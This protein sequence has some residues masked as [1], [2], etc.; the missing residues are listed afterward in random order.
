MSDV[1]VLVK[2]VPENKKKDEAI[3]V[4]LNLIVLTL[5]RVNR[6]GTPAKDF[7]QRR[8]KSKMSID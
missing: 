1:C 7:K 5:C 8:T 4:L 2:Q 6:V 3:N